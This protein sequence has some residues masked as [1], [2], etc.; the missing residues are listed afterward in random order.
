MKTDK[1]MYFLKLMNEDYFRVKLI[2]FYLIL[3]TVILINNFFVD[4]RSFKHRFY[5]NYVAN[6]SNL[7]SIETIV[8]IYKYFYFII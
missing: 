6:F 4:T 1:L 8:Q 7:Y 3:S 5:K 2:N